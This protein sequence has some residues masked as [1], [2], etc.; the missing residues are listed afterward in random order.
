MCSLFIVERLVRH[1]MESI[2]ENNFRPTHACLR[3]SQRKCAIYVQPFPF[4]IQLFAFPAKKLGGSKSPDREIYGR[5]ASAAVISVKN[6]KK[7][8]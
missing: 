8:L 4:I 1:R 3:H 2:Y 7:R 5:K 6:L